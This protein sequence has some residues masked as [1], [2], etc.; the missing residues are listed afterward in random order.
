M[1]REELV[2]WSE[3]RGQGA[4][5]VAGTAATRER[6]ASS[7]GH[8]QYNAIYPNWGGTEGQHT[9]PPKTEV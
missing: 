1:V 3:R 9:T 2:L 7:V 6:G 4:G 8:W 5:K